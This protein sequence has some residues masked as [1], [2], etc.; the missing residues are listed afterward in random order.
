M[1]DIGRAVHVYL[2]TIPTVTAIAGTRGSPGILKKDV[3]LPAYTYRVISSNPHGHLGGPFGAVESRV[4][5]D[6]YG[7]HL[8][9]YDLAERIR[10]AML[11]QTRPLEMNSIGVDRVR[12]EGGRDLEQPPTDGSDNWRRLRSDDYMILHDEAQP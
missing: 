1:A 6:C 5:I 2:Q 7:T 11:V 8:Q 4:Q 3:T 12:H 9:T 10:L